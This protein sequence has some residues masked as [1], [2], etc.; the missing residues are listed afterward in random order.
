MLGAQALPKITIGTYGWTGFVP[1]TLAERAAIFRANGI[2]LE[3][4]SVPQRERDPVLLGGRDGR[5]RLP[6]AG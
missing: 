2:E 1:F 3:A 6:D 4:K 5:P